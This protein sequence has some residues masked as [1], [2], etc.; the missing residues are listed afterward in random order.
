MTILGRSQIEIMGFTQDVLCVQEATIET[1]NRLSEKYEHTFLRNSN[2]I[3]V[4]Q[5]TQLHQYYRNVS[6]SVN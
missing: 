5:V 6:L 3:T 4:I 1:I 2:S